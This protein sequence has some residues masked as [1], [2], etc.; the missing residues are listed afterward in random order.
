MLNSGVIE[1]NYLTIIIASIAI[2]SG[3]LI[4]LQFSRQKYENQLKNL[5]DEALL[6][7]KALNEKIELNHSSYEGQIN[8]LNTSN[9]KLEEEKKLI[10]ESLEDKLKVIEKHSH[11][12]IDNVTATY[13]LKL[14]NLS[15]LSENK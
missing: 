9:R 8:T 5:Q 3:L 1:V 15:K 7:L 10:K 13:E 2:L 12:I 11:Q 14:S 4:I 6:K